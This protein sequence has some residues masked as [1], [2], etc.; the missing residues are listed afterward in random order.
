ME[1]FRALLTASYGRHYLAQRLVKDDRGNEYGNHEMADFGFYA[2]EIPACFFRLGT[3]NT[4]KG[5]THGVHTSKFDVDESA[6]EHG[7]GLL[8]WLA[9]SVNPAT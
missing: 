4:E 1:Q 8:A 3:R 9:V 6:M 5:I 7:A 2:Q